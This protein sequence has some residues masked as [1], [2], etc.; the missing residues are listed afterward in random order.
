MIYPNFPFDFLIDIA[1]MFG[2]FI[3]VGITIVIPM[4][5]K[6]K[7]IL[8]KFQARKTVHLFAG[9]AVLVTPFFTWPIYSIIIA[10]TLTFLTLKSSK[11][12]RVKQLR[13]LY[14]SIGE[15]EEEKVGFLQGP[16]HYCL[17]ITSL[18]AFFV[19]FVPHKLYFPIAGILLMIISDTLA[20]LVGKNYGKLSLKLPWTGPR[21]VEG[22]TTFFISAFLLCLFSFWFFGFNDVHSQVTLTM[23]EVILF[24]LLTSGI[25][26]GIELISPSTWDDL[27]VPIA[28]T[29][30]IFILTLF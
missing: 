23:Q 20:S 28:S 8:S 1:L 15:E 3:Y 25:A 14:E 29:F 24:S 18:I 13:E 19:F 30:L 21:T 27:T 17:S 10:G 5:L 12:S 16:F 26:T 2:A 4:F 22:S 11:K 9:L 7:E 6:K